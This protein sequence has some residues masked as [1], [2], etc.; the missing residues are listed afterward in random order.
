M[1]CLCGCGQVTK[2]AL[3]NHKG[4]G[5]KKGEH[6]RYIAGHQR[7]THGPGFPPGLN[8]LYDPEDEAYLMRY[9]W[10]LNEKGYLVRGKHI[11]LHRELIGVTDPK[12]HVDHANVNELSDVLMSLSMMEDYEK[13]EYGRAGATMLLQQQARIEE[14]E[15]KLSLWEEV[16]RQVVGHT[17]NE[18]TR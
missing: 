13:Q 4:N 10:Y 6:H 11:K 2:I 8:V 9:S 16:G 3:Y 14:L 17:S 18:G 1:M 5:W 7:R 12:T 15:A